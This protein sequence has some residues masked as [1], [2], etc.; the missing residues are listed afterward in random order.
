MLND[1]DKRIGGGANMKSIELYN[2][3]DRDFIT[4]GLFWAALIILLKSLHVRRCA[5]TL[6]SSALFLLLLK[7][8]RYIRICKLS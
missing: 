5:H 1:E 8:N 4:D 3:L 2:Q 7:V 6:K